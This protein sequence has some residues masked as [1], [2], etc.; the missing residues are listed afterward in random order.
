MP[1]QSKNTNAFCLNKA[2]CFRFLISH[3]RHQ[4]GMCAAQIYTS[5]FST[6]L[7]T[8][9]NLLHTL[10]HTSTPTEQ[11][12]VV[13]P[14]P[15]L[16]E[17]KPGWNRLRSHSGL[18]KCLFQWEVDMSRSSEENRPLP[19]LWL[20]SPSAFRGAKLVD[21]RP[22]SH[23]R[24]H[25]RTAVWMAFFSVSPFLFPSCIPNFFW[26]HRPDHPQNGSWKI[27]NRG[28]RPIICL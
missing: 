4:D 17:M 15:V 8:S 21:H 1:P 10:T 11:I 12:H 18:E 7:Y 20:N 6:N 25:R 9:G 13:K 14:S 5:I 24:S 23:H 19:E 2:S 27:L 16:P 28:G 22:D 3:K 26:T